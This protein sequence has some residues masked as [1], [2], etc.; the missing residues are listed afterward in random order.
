MRNGAWNELPELTT[1]WVAQGVEC[2]TVCG[3]LTV[4]TL[5]RNIQSLEI[6]EKNG[7]SLL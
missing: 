3:R 5:D 4:Q 2:W 6:T 1:D 7:L